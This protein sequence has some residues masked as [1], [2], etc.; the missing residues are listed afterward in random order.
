MT[1]KLSILIPTTPC[2]A[3]Y[4]K[5]LFVTFHSLLGNHTNHYQVWPTGED[6][7][8][9]VWQFQ[10]V[11]IITYE[12]NFKYSVGYKRNKLLDQAIG[13]YVAFVDSDDQV[14]HGYFKNVFEGIAK[15]VDACSLKGVIT[16]NGANP[17]LFEHSIKYN[18]Y[19]TN[20]PDKE[21]RYERFPNHIS[22]I[23][24]KIAKQFKFPDKNHSED[25]EWATQIHK[26]GLIKTEHYIEETIYLYDFR[27][28]K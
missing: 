27:S 19:K 13:E 25:T 9:T 18:E 8:I 15:G 17:L 2:R 5:S 21:I 24:S 22:C 6:D 28:K 10:E 23:K 4:L 20:E 1:P 3:D 12:D 26:S 14:K 16:E 7:V 11:E